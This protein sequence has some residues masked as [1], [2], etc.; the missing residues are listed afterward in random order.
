MTTLTSFPIET[1]TVSELTASITLEDTDLMHIE[2]GGVDKQITGGTLKAS[3]LSGVEGVPVGI[4]SMWSGLAADIPSGYLLCDGSGGTPNLV[5]KFIMGGTVA[6][7]TGG[8][9][10]HTHS[11]NFAVANHTLTTSQMPSHS[12]TTVYPYERYNTSGS[13]NL[14]GGDGSSS[15]SSAINSTGGGGSHGHG[16]T[17]GVSSASNLPPYYILCFIIKV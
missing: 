16:L 5:D 2:Q 7:A 11:D 4:I 17:G 10:A 14:T 12:H 1:K 8:E 9:S 3:I 6:G 15:S 13:N